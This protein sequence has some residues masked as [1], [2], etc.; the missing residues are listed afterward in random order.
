MFNLVIFHYHFLPGGVTD[1]VTSAVISY[2]THNEFINRIT[3]VSGR[4]ANLDRLIQKIKET[5]PTSRTLSIE[6]HIISS[7]D[8]QEN[9]SNDVT[10]ESIKRE[11][12]DNF[13]SNKNIWWIHNYHL[14]KNPYFTEALLEISNKGIQN[15]IFQ[16]HD[17]PECSR[18]ALM[19][20]LNKKISLDLYPQN[21]NTKYVVINNRD[22]K[23]LIDAGIN[24]KTVTLLEN[25]IQCIDWIPEIDNQVLHSLSEHYSSAFPGWKNNKSYMLYP[26]R[27]IRRKNIAEAAL[28][29][30]LSDKNIIISLPG[31]SDSEIQYSK[32]CEEIFTEGLSPGMFG[33]GFTIEEHNLSFRDLI[34]SSS[35]IISSSVQEGFGYLFLNSMNWGKPLLGKDL[36][37][38]TSFKE[39]FNGFPSYF[40][41]SIHVPLD[42][43]DRH[44]LESEY[45]NKIQSLKNELKSSKIEQLDLLIPQLFANEFV[46]FSYLT[47]K[48]QIKVLRKI[49]TDKNFKKKCEEK[50]K[51]IIKIID[52]F[53]AERVTG[54]H[55]ILQKNWSFESYSLKTNEILRSFNENSDIW[56]QKTPKNS[57]SE[58]LQN[59][60][61]SLEYLRLL[62]DE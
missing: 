12:L 16:I 31:V 54:N 26:V 47:L 37:I 9:L 19:N 62:Y 24:E 40:Y 59:Y 6:S 56:E 14:G 11:I 10:T 33:I 7:I 58:T 60:F 21:K 28:L 30:S 18:Y 22:Y 49:K 42:L 50:N 51:N 15:M 45:T 27:A 2:L 38:L 43:S 39:S 8:Y 53:F 17:F 5:I 55:E 34:N 4:P 13:S 25:P 20:R 35:M 29:A 61:A 1:V 52:N 41:K 48:L 32:S 23:N 36:D 46:D 3:I 44:Y 57:T